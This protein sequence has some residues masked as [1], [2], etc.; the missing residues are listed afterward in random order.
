MFIAVPQEAGKKYDTDGWQLWKGVTSC[1]GLYDF[2]KVELDK[3]PDSIGVTEPVA[4]DGKITFILHSGK[5][6]S[7]KETNKFRNYGARF[8]CPIC[9]EITAD[10]YVKQQG[11][12]HLTIPVVRILRSPTLRSASKR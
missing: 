3:K 10:E 1:G 11:L 4:T 7:D 5:C 12:M 2:S 6:P 9:G 8:I